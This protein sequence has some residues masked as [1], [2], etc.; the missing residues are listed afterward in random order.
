MHNGDISFPPPLPALLFPRFP[1]PL[2]PC[3]P[4]L[5]A[6]TSSG[7]PALA[8]QLSGSPA[9]G[10]RGVGRHLGEG[11]PGQ[12]RA[13]PGRRLGHCPALTKGAVAGLQGREAGAAGAA[14]AA[15]SAA[16][17]SVAAEGGGRPGPG[18]RDA[19]GRWRGAQPS[20]RAFRAPGAQRP[21]IQRHLSRLRR[22]G[23]P[24]FGCR[25]LC[26]CPAERPPW[27]FAGSASLGIHNKPTCARPG[28]PLS[29]LHSQ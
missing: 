21:G 28:I 10:E 20:C 2:I 23:W 26:I 18:E 27:L 6:D 25:C 14:W 16:R 1:P 3:T 22:A 7:T 4:L 12:G 13:G 15:E 17:K 11:S 8:S 19:R 9:L 29:P 24:P 5:P